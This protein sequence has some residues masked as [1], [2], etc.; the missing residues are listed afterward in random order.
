MKKLALL[1]LLFGI[2]S[3]SFSQI[4]KDLYDT[5]PWDTITFEKQY[6][7][8][9]IDTFPQN[10]WQIGQPQKVYFDSSYSAIKAIVTD[11]VTSYPIDN[12]SYFDIKIGE[13]NYNYYYM[14]YV[15]MEIKHK[16]DTDTLKDGGYI[17]V[18][19]DNGLT[20]MNIINDTS[21]YYDIKPSDNDWWPNTSLY[22]ETDTLYNG[23]FG[24]SGKS[25]GWQTTFFSWYY[26]PVKNDL[27]WVDT[28]LIRFNFISDN[29]DNNKEG[30]MIDDIKLCSVDLGSAYNE[31][32]VE[33]FSIYPNPM[34]KSSTIV[35]QRK[36]ETIQTL[37]IDIHGNVITKQ[38]HM[39]CDSFVL[40]RNNIP[41]GIYFLKIIGDNKLVGINK[42][43]IE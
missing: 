3:I 24:F 20:W 15:G 27:N 18:S 41:R 43:A 40:H 25:E 33:E 29:I 6:E 28:T 37:L 14:Y 17:S 31:N 30:W 36:Y 23:E 9:E 19:Y 39:N 1:T 2:Y 12:H 35:L 34:I 11:T 26:I 10:I 5:L 13:F 21:D 22:S 8:L 38:K 32:K 42:I 16:F 4:T 7:F